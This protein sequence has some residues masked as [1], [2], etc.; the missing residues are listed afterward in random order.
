LS[1]IVRITKFVGSPIAL[2]VGLA[3]SSIIVTL[4]GCDCLAAAPLAFVLA[5]TGFVETMDAE[6]V[7]SLL[8]E[9]KTGILL[10]LDLFHALLIAT[11]T[12]AFVTWFGLI[13]VGYALF[14]TATVH[15]TLLLVFLSATDRLDATR[16]LRALGVAVGCFGLAGFGVAYAN[17]Q[18]NSLLMA[19]LLLSAAVAGLIF[20]ETKER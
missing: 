3:A 8:G 10:R 9:G 19:G 5:V 18:Q 20:M 1:T 15:A 17:A 7:S 16:V 2:I 13:G 12:T 6:S 14:T 4:Y 11:A